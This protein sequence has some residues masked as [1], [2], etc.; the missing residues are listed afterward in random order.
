MGVH[1]KLSMKSFW[2]FH[3]QEVEFIDLTP[4]GDVGYLNLRSTRKP[5]CYIDK[6]MNNY[7]RAYFQTFPSLERWFWIQTPWR[8][9]DLSLHERWARPEGR[10][11]RWTVR[12]SLGASFPLV[13]S[14]SL[15]G[16][17]KMCDGMWTSQVF[18]WESRQH[19]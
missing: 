19:G 8:I 15:Q 6:P 2:E 3:Q 10:S 12:P 13:F 11:P 16:M 1:G 9:L 7:L 17:V 5:S 14:V 4:D 18:K